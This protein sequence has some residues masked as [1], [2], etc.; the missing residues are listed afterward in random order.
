M[1]EAFIGEIRLF[2]FSFAPQ[3]WLLCQGQLLSVSQN[4]ALFS[5]LG[6][7]YGGDGQ[8][9]FKLPDLRGRFPT[10]WGQGPLGNTLYGGV[11][12]TTG[13]T[14]NTTAS[15]TLT[16]ANQ[17]P[18]HTHTAT[19]TGTGSAPSTSVPPTITIKVSN[20]TA[21]AAGG[22][23]AMPINGG[24]IGKAASTAGQQPAIYTAGATKGTTTLNAATATATGGSYGGGGITGGTVAVDPTGSSQP[25]SI[26][27]SFGVPAAMP[28][29]LAMN[30]AIC[31]VGIYPSRP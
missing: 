11:G 21:A 28:P 29:F 10:Q 2:A 9:N 5:L 30:Y 15:F 4:A 27:L 8:S 7:T 25:I 14:V 22:A 6:T 24:Y 20:D 12:G 16:N 31:V 23:G 19:F 13:A 17:L 1:A 26:P 3:D 18:A